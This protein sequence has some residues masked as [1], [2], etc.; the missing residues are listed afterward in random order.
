MNLFHKLLT[1]AERP[2]GDPLKNNYKAMRVYWYQ[3][4]GRFV[5]HIRINPHK[6]Y[7]YGMTKE[8]LF[9]IVYNRWGDKTKVEMKFIMDL[10][11]DVIYVYN[12]TL[13]SDEDIKSMKFFMHHA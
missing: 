3:V 13:C 2:E 10:Q 8:E 6:I 1:N 9:D 5:T 4:P 7:D 12:N 11:K